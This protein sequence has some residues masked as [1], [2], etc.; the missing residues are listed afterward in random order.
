MRERA[1]KINQQF[2]GP[3]Q[4]LTFYKIRFIRQ[5]HDKAKQKEPCSLLSPSGFFICF[6]LHRFLSYGKK[7]FVQPRLPGLSLLGILYR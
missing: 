3:G 6:S 5:F 4:L 7:R 2:S 1:T